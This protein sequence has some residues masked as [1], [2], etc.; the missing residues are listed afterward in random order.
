MSGNI[1]SHDAYSAKK[2]PLLRR[3][4]DILYLI[5]TEKVNSIVAHKFLTFPGSI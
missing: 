5:L 4:V 2:R 3:M 1:D